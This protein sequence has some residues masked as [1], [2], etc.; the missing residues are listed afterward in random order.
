MGYKGQ[1]YNVHGIEMMRIS[2]FFLRVTDQ[3]MMRCWK[4]KIIIKNVNGVNN[5]YQQSVCG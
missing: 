2:V 3:D 4:I 1:I 5:S